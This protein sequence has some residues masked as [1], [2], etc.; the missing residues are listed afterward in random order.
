[1]QAIAA[2]LGGKAVVAFGA[3]PFVPGRLPSVTRQEGTSPFL[4]TV[5][6]WCVA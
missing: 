4:Q 2:V 1:V 5:R 6:P 3:G